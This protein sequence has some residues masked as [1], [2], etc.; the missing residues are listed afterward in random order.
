[1]VGDRQVADAQRTSRARAG[2][3]RAGL[4]L[5]LLGPPAAHAAAGQ[6][7]PEEEAAR[8][9]AQEFEKLSPASLNH[10][11][12]TSPSPPGALRP[13][14]IERFRSQSSRE[15]AARFARP[16]APSSRGTS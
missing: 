7:R 14:R 11:A 2:R 10:E 3:G 1:R 16:A 4:R 12:I 8:S 13:A 5:R 15:E 6:R 9:N